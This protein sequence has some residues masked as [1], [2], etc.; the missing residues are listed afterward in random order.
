MRKI[1]MSVMITAVP[2]LAL[3]GEGQPQGADSGPAPG[4]HYASFSPEVLT[5]YGSPATV[6][7]KIQKRVPNLKARRAFGVLVETGDGIAESCLFERGDEARDS[8]A[9]RLSGRDA[10]GLK[11]EIARV[12]L[13]NEGRY[14]LGDRIVKDIL[15]GGMGDRLVTEHGVRVPESADATLASML[16]RRKGAVLY[17]RVT[18][19]LLC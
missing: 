19:F 16:E 18:V 10:A 4:C 1:L 8:T 7:D 5:F 13:A 15:I 11:D 9:Y 3:G 6:L 2:V 14:C 12:S 17:V